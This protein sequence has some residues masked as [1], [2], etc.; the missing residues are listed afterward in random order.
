VVR[1]RVKLIIETCG[2]VPGEAYN[3]NMWYGT[4]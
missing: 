4:G 3:R 1:Y 2:T